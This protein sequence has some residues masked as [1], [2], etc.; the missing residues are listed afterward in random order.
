MVAGAAV[1]GMAAVTALA[2]VVAVATSVVVAVA[3]WGVPYRE[4]VAAVA[5]RRL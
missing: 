1:T 4:E 3:L 5:P 2:A